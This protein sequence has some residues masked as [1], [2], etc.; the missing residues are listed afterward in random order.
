M[1]Q[2]EKPLESLAVLPVL[3]G[4]VFVF[5]AFGLSYQ[6]V[7]V[8]LIKSE[9]DY[10]LLK[11]FAVGMAVVVV[12]ALA[13]ISITPLGDIWLINVAGLSRELADFARLPLLL[14]TIFPA[15]TVWINFQRSILVCARNTKPITY[16]STI[17]VVL[18]LLMLLITVKF[19]SMIG[20]IAAVVA[21]TVG[22][23]F[24]NGYLIMPFEK[25]KLKIFSK[26]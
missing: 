23:L 22:R 11:K 7:G 17:E 9:R 25:A 21:Y 19:F 1:G 3:N 18:I 4:L 6:E 26:A 20:V 13:S 16:A 14:Y 24:A 12:I 10:F 5:R 8:A 15:T 2:S